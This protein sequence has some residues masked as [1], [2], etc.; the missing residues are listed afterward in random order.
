MHYIIEQDNGTFQNQYA[1]Q[2]DA[3][4]SAQINDED[5]FLAFHR[6][7]CCKRP[8]FGNESWSTSR[9]SHRGE[10]HMDTSPYRSLYSVR[11]QTTVDDR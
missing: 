1:L 4:I 7:I 8:V 2:V 11:F 9:L 10:I 3:N 6:L 5:R